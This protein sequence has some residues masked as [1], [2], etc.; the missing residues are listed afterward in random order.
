[1]S[2]AEQVPSPEV[3]L[4]RAKDMHDT[5]L[6]RAAEARELRRVPEQTIAEL[7]QAGFFRTMPA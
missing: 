3:F 4:Q 7:K 1:M 6:A 2:A 5:L